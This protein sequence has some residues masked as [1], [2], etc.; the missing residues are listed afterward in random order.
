MIC[1]TT[2]V[3]VRRSNSPGVAETNMRWPIRSRNSSQRSGRLSAAL[4]ADGL[5]ARTDA[6]TSAAVLR[7]VVAAVVGFGGWVIGVLAVMI[8]R[9]GVPVDDQL[10][11]VASVG[12]PVGLAAYL[13][14]VHRDSSARS[15]GVGL[16]AAAGGALVGAWLGFQATA[17]L[18]ALVTAILGAVAG[19]NLVLILLDMARASSADYRTST[20]P[21]PDT[22]S[23]SAKPE[24]P[25][26]AGMR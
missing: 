23:A 4:V 6:I 16:A 21:A 11:V 19:A 5:H 13:A 1:S 24:T 20:D 7:S 14:W 9:P 15:K 26:S 22:Q 25:T 8:A 10:L 12:V 2:L 17:G 18:M 3:A